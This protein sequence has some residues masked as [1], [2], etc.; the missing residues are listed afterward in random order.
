MSQVAFSCHQVQRNASYLGLAERPRPFDS[1]GSGL[2]GLRLGSEELQS[3]TSSQVRGLEMSYLLPPGKEAAENTLDS[4]ENLHS[5]PSI[6]I[7]TKLGLKMS[8]LPPPN[9]KLYYRLIFVQLT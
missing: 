7:S 4:Q 5:T 6:L 3:E 9:I 8:P 2:R 1:C